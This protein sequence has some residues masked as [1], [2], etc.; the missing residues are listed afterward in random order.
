MEGKDGRTGGTDWK[1]GKE[2]KDYQVG[3]FGQS[4]ENSIYV[5]YNI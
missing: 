2:R 3:L 4:T 1:D 5:L